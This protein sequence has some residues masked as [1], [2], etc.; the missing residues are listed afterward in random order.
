MTPH[1]QITPTYEYFIAFNFI[2]SF[3]RILPCK[4]IRI[5]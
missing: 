1:Y 5:N 4:S 3:W 2:D